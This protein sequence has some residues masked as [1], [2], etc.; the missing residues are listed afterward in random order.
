M[1]A[2]RVAAFRRQS[3]ERKVRAPYSGV[4]G[5]AR[6]SE[7]ED[8]SHRDES[9]RF[10]KGETRQSLRGARPNREG[11]RKIRNIGIDWCETASF[12]I[13]SG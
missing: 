12:A 13:T 9:S 3:G 4:A 8:K 6:P 5:N 7:G 10:G 2:D 11:I 1:E